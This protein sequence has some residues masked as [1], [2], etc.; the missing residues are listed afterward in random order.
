VALVA[1]TS[2]TSDA[3]QP[4]A[5]PARPRL[6]LEPIA[7]PPDSIDGDNQAFDTLPLEVGRILDIRALL[8]EST[9]DPGLTCVPLSY[10]SDRSR[11]QRIQGRP[12]DGRGLV[13]FARVTRAGALARVEFVRRL[14]TGGQR[15]YTW[16]AQGDATTAMEW[17]AGST[18]A[19]SFP[20]PRGSPIPRAVRALGRL[21]LT[22]RCAEG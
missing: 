2:G 16:D 5:Q 13:V 8:R 6:V 10:T 21:A 14:E 11:R 20:V 3:Q 17:P 9:R 19:E 15:G 12:A 1:L 18:Q 4:G 22:W 7:L